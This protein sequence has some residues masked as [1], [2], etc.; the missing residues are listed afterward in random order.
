[1]RAGCGTFTP[2]AKTPFRS[3][4]HAERGFRGRVRRECRIR[5]ARCLCDSDTTISRPRQTEPPCGLLRS[6]LSR[7]SCPKRHA[8]QW[9]SGRRRTPGK[10]VYVKS[11]SR[12][13]IPPAPPPGFGG[14][15]PLSLP[16]RSSRLPSAKANSI[17]SV[18]ERHAPPPGD[19]TGGALWNTPTF[20]QLRSGQRLHRGVSLARFRFAA[21]AIGSADRA[22]QAKALCRTPRRSRRL[23][24]MHTHLTRNFR[25]RQNWIMVPRRIWRRNLA[26]P[27]APMCT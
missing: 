27:I 17:A 6:P 24:Y 7:P 13:R 8:E 14:A 26:H 11:V 25:T 23:I 16:Q 22:R 19:R 4:R 12:V 9:P 18:D 1:M 3:P 5:A 21:G 2:Q 10:C 15:V 20:S